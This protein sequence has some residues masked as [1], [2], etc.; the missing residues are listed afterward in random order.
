MSVLE[1]FLLFLCS[2]NENDGPLR[3]QRITAI[4]DKPT[5][6]MKLKYN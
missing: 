6:T 4:I 1:M 3:A 2:L 5:E